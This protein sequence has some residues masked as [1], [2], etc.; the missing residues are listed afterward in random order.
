LKVHKDRCLRYLGSAANNILLAAVLGFLLYR[1]AIKPWSSSLALAVWTVTALSFFL[2]AVLRIVWLKRTGSDGLGIVL[3]RSYNGYLPVISTFLV[4]FTLNALKAAPLASETL[5]QQPNLIIPILIVHAVTNVVLFAGFYWGKPILELGVATGLVLLLPHYVGANLCIYG[6]LYLLILAIGFIRAGEPGAKYPSPSALDI[7]LLAFLGL[8]TI[9]TLASQCFWA[10]ALPLV[11]IVTSIGAGLLIA[12]TTKRES[13]LLR[14]VLLATLGGVFLAAI[15]GAKLWLVARN[16]GPR[17]AL[18]NRLWLPGINPNSVAA[19][20]TLTIPLMLAVLLARVRR[21]LSVAFAAMIVVAIGCLVLSYSKGGWLGFAAAMIS[22]GL[23][24][25]KKKPVGEN[26]RRTWATVAIILVVSLL[27]GSVFLGEVGQK[28]LQRFADPISV[29]SRA[30]FWSLA[31]HVISTHPLIGVGLANT[32]LHARSA[33]KVPTGL[34]V[35]VRQNVLSHSHSTYLHLGEGTGILG[36]CA[37]L[38]LLVTFITRGIF[39]IGAIPSTTLS[40]ICRGTVAS[41]IGYAVHGLFDLDFFVFSLFCLIGITL[42]AERVWHEQAAIKP[43]YTRGAWARAKA[44]FIACFTIMALLVT[45]IQVSLKSELIWPSLAS[46]GLS[47]N[48]QFFERLAEQSIQQDRFE[49]ATKLL[50][51]AIARRRDYALYHEKLGWLYWL[52]AQPDRAAKHFM[53]AVE[54]DPLGA[55]GDEHYSALAPAS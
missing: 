24:R 20:L 41:I 4:L 5:K 25:P 23:L 31:Q 54:C 30:F 17:F 32:Y 35:D 39:L 22:F 44:L 52:L 16:L 29:S 34:E 38:F 3:R 1:T 10:S 42:A 28:A 8:A 12:V 19:N 55:I 11:S 18:T 48:P 21:W 13:Q 40:L 14:L 43:N 2:C 49:A 37:Y 15:G 27:L 46:A 26:R 45:I 36:L 7:P 50:E 9:S 53:A 47:V 51:K 33:D 6:T